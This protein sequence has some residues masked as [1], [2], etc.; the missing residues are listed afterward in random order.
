[1]NKVKNT[2]NNLTM[3]R[4]ALYGLQILFVYSLILGFLGKLNF[5]VWWMIISYFVLAVV[6]WCTNIL[7]ARIFG[8]IVNFESAAITSSILFLIYSP[9]NSLS[10][11]EVLVGVGVVA[12]LSKYI[13]AI[14]GKHIF[15][16]AALSALVVGMLGFGSAS[17]W[18]ASP[19]MLPIVVLV[20]V[21]LVWKLKKLMVT[22]LFMAFSIVSIFINNLSLINQPLTFG[23]E[24]VTS[25]PVMFFGF[26]M[27]SEPST[28]PGRRH[29]QFVY[30]GLVGALFGVN[31]S[32][33]PI[34]TTPELV[35]VCGNLFS[36][37]VSSR[38]GL[39]L[40]LN[41]IKEVAQTIYEF[42]F[43]GDRIDFLP[44]QYMEWTLDF[45]KVDS[46]GN[47]RY[48]TM[49]SSPSEKEIVIATKITDQVS[50][51]KRALK[52]MKKGQVIQAT[53]LAGDFVLGSNKEMVW[54]AGGIGVTPFRSMAKW[55][56]DNNK[57][58]KVV[59][60]YACNMYE[61]IA[62]RD[63]FEEAKK[64]GVELVEVMKDQSSAKKS[65][66]GETGF[67]TV[68]MIKKYVSDY[69]CRTYYLSGP[70]IMVENYTNML[71]EMGIN[72]NRIITDFF[73]GY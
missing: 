39:K 26:F 58:V 67:V 42:R 32:A 34:Y 20:G 24:V 6:C 69:Q 13:L 14:R 7:V 70:N 29:W 61:E 38:K 51:Y 59:L 49:A 27:F 65:W 41:S 48:F 4:M 44:G 3:Y 10:G 73:P 5:E 2:L 15:N 62:Y 40:K 46:R 11:L 66:K 8:V 9:A 71:H 28:M 22:G 1:M 36:Y 43:S 64:V 19:L 68:D 30:A 54:I 17:W 45:R 37:V 57:Q 21:L 25:W 52:E 12:M 16:P 18:I 31:I 23:W 33:G 55:L 53:N 60:F 63:V 47:R 50:A 35:L 72:Q 56:M